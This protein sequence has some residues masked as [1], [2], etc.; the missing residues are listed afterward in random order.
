M[1]VAFCF[2]APDGCFAETRMYTLCSIRVHAWGSVGFK[3][4]CIS[5]HMRGCDIPVGDVTDS[6]RNT[7]FIK[8]C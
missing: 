2:E 3:G 4:S 6:F 8:L 7:V 5:S 1:T